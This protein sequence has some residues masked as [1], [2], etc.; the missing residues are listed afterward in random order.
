MVRLFSKISK[1]FN[2]SMASVN[3]L[4]V[5]LLV[6]KTC[7]NR[8]KLNFFSNIATRKTNNIISNRIRLS[9]IRKLIDN[10]ENTKVIYNIFLD[11]NFVVSKSYLI[12]LELIFYECSSL[13]QLSCFLVHHQKF[14]E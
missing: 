9:G 13:E 1:F 11:I 12:H 5:G 14:Y 8:N 7:R 4:S 10:N 2:P 6:T 3:S